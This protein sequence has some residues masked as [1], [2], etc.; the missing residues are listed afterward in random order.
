MEPSRH[1]VRGHGG[2]DCKALP[3]LAAEL[4]KHLPVLLG[5]NAFG[6]NAKPKRGGKPE[7]GFRMAR[8]SGLQGMSLTKLRSILS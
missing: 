2:S 6:D 1:G 4:Q 8:S 7:D 5:L 3:H